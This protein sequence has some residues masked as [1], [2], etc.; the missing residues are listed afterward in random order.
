MTVV[1][2]AL[3]VALLLAVA[4]AAG[5]IVRWIGVRDHA[6]ELGEQ[7]ARDNSWPAGNIVVGHF[8]PL[9]SEDE[10]PA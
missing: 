2:A 6:A 7:D 5:E 10:P 3:A 9:E 8:P 4:L 1:Y